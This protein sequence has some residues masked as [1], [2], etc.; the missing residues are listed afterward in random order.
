MKTRVTACPA[1]L[2]FL[3]SALPVICQNADDNNSLIRNWQVYHDQGEYDKAIEQARLIYQLGEN[4][5]NTGLM[6][7]ALNWEGQSLLKQPKR[8]SANRR[9]ARKAFE[10]SL[11]LMVSVDNKSLQLDNLKHLR[12]IAQADNDSQTYARYDKQINTLENL[13]VATESNKDLAEK[14]VMLDSEKKNLRKRVDA[15]NAAQMKAELM[16][17]MQKNY[18][19]S[20]E[21]VR[22]HEAFELEKSE[23]A[24]KE[25]NTQVELQQS[26]I[27]LQNNQIRLQ[28]SQRNF[29]IAIAAVLTLLAIGAFIRYSEIKKY[30]IALNA[31]NEAL[32]EERERSDMLLLNILPAMVADEL[33]ENGATQ[34]RRYE[35]ATVMFTDFQDF[36]AIAKDL[37]P[38][39][40]VAELDY[41]F[42]AFDEI[43]DKYQIEKIKTIGDA[44]M[45]VGGLPDVEG[46]KPR[47]VVLAALEIQDL[48]AQLKKDREKRRQPWF[49]ARIGIHTGPLVAGVVGSRKFAYDIW[50]DTVNVASRLETNGKAWQVNISETTYELVRDHFEVEERG[51]I[52]IKNR[53]EIGMY[54]V[55][56]KPGFRE[57]VY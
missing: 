25:K 16:L 12:E 9:N 40:L 14:V 22:M 29:F 57:L 19:D 20:L 15:L 49:E 8:Q 47:D 52:P 18:V 42:K 33:K 56:P 7:Q 4:T 38:E 45:C 3:W 54:F 48:L 37:P 17:A 21:M 13:A 6:A 53:G 1:I 34:A 51:N 32:V 26:Q 35:K 46:S 43:I 36:S 28:S 27:N 41:Y 50:G 5:Q 10:K 2:L 23:L 30:N 31:K 44:Y 24:L 11:E 55:K 39:Q